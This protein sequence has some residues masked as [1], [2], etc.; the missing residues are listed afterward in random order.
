MFHHQ[1]KTTFDHRH[2]MEDSVMPRATL[3]ID[4]PLLLKNVLFTHLVAMELLIEQLP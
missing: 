1:R 4:S 2:I 3:L